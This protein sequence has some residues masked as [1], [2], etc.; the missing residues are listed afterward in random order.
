ME[1]N[2]DFEVLISQALLEVQKDLA[3]HGKSAGKT[4]TAFQEANPLPKIL[5]FSSS[6]WN[7]EK[8]N[9]ANLC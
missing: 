4:C 3:L 9:K 6:R 1:R 2:K 8:K 7:E 5:T